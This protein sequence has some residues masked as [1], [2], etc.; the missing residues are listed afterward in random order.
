MAATNLLPTSLDDIITPIIVKPVPWARRDARV[1]VS[2]SPTH[3]KTQETQETQTTQKFVSTQRPTQEFD[4][5]QPQAHEIVLLPSTNDETDTLTRD[6]P[7][8][9]LIKCHMDI[10]SD[11]QK[12][13]LKKMQLWEKY[14]I[15]ERNG[16]VDPKSIYHVD[17]KQLNERHELELDI[18]YKNHEFIGANLYAIE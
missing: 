9:F 10:E 7:D 17:L 6:R 13:K 18:M 11:R 8:A 12:Y 5:T 1:T 16:V 14:E 2:N 3:Q 15:N 4:S